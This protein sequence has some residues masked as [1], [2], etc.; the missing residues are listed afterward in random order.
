MKVVLPALCLLVLAGCDAHKGDKALG[1]VAECWSP[2]TKNAAQL[3]AFQDVLSDFTQSLPSGMSD[4]DVNKT[5]GS[6]KLRLSDFFVE[7][8]DPVSGAADCGAAYDFSY[9]RPDGISYSDDQGNTVDFEVYQAENGQ[10]IVVK[11]DDYDPE[12][13]QYEDDGGDDGGASS[14]IT[15]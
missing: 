10:K 9:T 12:S 13:F 6:M 15:Q 5:G 3:A 1:S 11:G 2:E 7:S 4:A 8:Y 14:G